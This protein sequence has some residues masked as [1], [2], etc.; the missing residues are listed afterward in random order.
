MNNVK[1]NNNN[2]SSCANSKLP[3]YENCS[4]NYTERWVSSTVSIP[5]DMRLSPDNDNQHSS[6]VVIEGNGGFVPKN[7]PLQTLSTPNGWPSAQQDHR[8]C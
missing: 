1:C 3:I 2:G 4:E 8:V 6:S 7:Q 5:P